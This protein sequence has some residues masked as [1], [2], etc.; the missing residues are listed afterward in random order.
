MNM[1]KE[2]DVYRINTSQRRYSAPRKNE[3]SFEDSIFDPLKLS[4]D[5]IEYMSVVETQNAQAW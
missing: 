1:I 3:A 4:S 2:L 5:E